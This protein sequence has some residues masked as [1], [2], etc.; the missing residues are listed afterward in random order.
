MKPNQ[1]PE[2]EESLDRVLRRWNVGTPLPPRFQE[3]VW[4][5]I[6]RAEIQ[7][8]TTLWAGFLRL[9]EV[10]LPRPR[11]AFAY[12]AAWLVLGVVAGTA[13][14]QLRAGHLEATLSARYIQSVNPYHAEASQP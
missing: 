5:R 11:I 4:Q 10:G 9:V 3:Q 7:P 12:V 8:R 13:T 2:N 6:S 14:A 1:D